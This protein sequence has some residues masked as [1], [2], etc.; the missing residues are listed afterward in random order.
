MHRPFMK[1]TASAIG[2]LALI[3]VAACEQRSETTPANT[4][5]P[6][7][8]PNALRPAPT[9]PSMGNPSLPTTQERTSAQGATSRKIPGEDPDTMPVSGTDS[10]LLG[11]GGS[12][13]GGHGGQGGH[14]GHAGHAGTSP[15]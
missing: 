2:T 7:Q 4:T 12:G 11:A 8:E 1:L 10:E 14:A 9:T 3:S 15:H 13:H 6:A 5:S